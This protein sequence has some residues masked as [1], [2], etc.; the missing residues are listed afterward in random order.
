MRARLVDESSQLPYIEFDVPLHEFNNNE[1]YRTSIINKLHSLPASKICL[2][3]S[4]AAAS[5]T[6]LFKNNTETA[7][8]SKPN[9]NHVWK[10]MGNMMPPDDSQIVFQLSVKHFNQRSTSKK[11]SRNPQQR[12]PAGEISDNKR[13]AIELFSHSLEQTY[14]WVARNSTLPDRI[15]SNHHSPQRTHIISFQV[16]EH[17][18][19]STDEDEDEDE[20]FSLECPILTRT[21]PLLDP[22]R[23][24]S[25]KR[26]ESFLVAKA[27]NIQIN[28]VVWDPMCK[29]GTFVIEAAKYWPVANYFCMDTSVGHL[30]HVRMN[31]DSTKSKIQQVLLGSP[32][33]LPVKDGTIDTI[34]TCIIPTSSKKVVVADY[35]NYYQ[36]IFAEWAR[37]LK[38]GGMMTLV[39]DPQ[40]I[41]QGILGQILPRSCRVRFVRSKTIKW[42]KG[43]SAI[44]VIEKMGTSKEIG[45][46][47]TKEA[48]STEGLFEWEKNNKQTLGKLRAETVPLMVPVTYHTSYKTTTTSR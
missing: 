29:R 6:S 23:T 40:Y 16:V 9:F 25:T 43:R 2:V 44:V 8:L 5:V 15:S 39:I 20:E 41:L 37:A 26:L 24:S 11:H 45:T 21:W 7:L 30:D 46:G 10:S 31:A 47:D 3:V 36:K 19:H 14:G 34:M 32:D 38:I 17:C 22:N 42:G 35:H 12:Q 48:Y 1:H 4:S 27:S 28:N 33:H 18:R 13:K